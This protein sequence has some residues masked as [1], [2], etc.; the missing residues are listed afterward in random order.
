MTATP[1]RGDGIRLTGVFDDILFSRDLRWGI[2]NSWLS[3]IRCERVVASYELAGV[4]MTGGD[5]NQGELDGAMVPEKL[6]VAARTYLDQCHDRGRHTLIYC[7]SVHICEILHR[8]ITS[9]LPEQDQG[10]VRLLTGKTAAEERKAVLEKF[11]EGSVRCI[12]NCMV[13]TE[14]TDLPVCDVVINLRPTCNVSLYQQ[15]VGRGTR[16]YDGKDYYLVI[17]IVPNDERKIRNLCTAPTLFGVE[18][19]LLPDG[20][21]ERF[22][23][24]N[25]LLELRDEIAGTIGTT[26]DMTGRMEIRVV[27]AEAFI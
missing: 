15:I 23:E 12:I 2:Q 18:P 20:V 22:N 5:F 16:L 14:G 8:T 3:S 24:K 4:G 25:D 26:E 7:V 6:A 21:T 1:K 27:L 9:F 10:S 17:D 11:Q 13:L 19:R